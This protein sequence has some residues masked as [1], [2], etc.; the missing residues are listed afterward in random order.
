MDDVVSRIIEN[1]GSRT[2]G[3]L[4]LRFFLQPA[5]ALLLG[6]GDGLKDAREQRPAYFWSIFT[7]RDDRAQLVKSGLKSVAKLLCIALVLDAIFQAIGFRWFYPG[8]AIL[9][10]LTLAFVPY[11]VIR[12]P[13]NRVAGWWTS[14]RV[15]RGRGYGV[16]R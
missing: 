5:M 13:A 15:S 9:V 6:I 16:S 3:P 2:S 14:R 7:R 1:L 11:L 4:H 8:E 10:A 12:G